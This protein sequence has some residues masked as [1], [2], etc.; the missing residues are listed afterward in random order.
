MLNFKINIS[1]GFLF[2]MLCFNSSL[3]FS[4][5]KDTITYTDTSIYKSNSMV[6]PQ[7]EI[8]PDSLNGNKIDKLMPENRQ[9]DRLNNPFSDMPSLKSDS[10]HKNKAKDVSLKQL[11]DSSKIKNGFKSMAVKLIPDSAGKKRLLKKL[12]PK[13]YGNI[14]AGYDYGVIPFAANA[15]YP[16]G[17]FKTQGNIGASILGIPILATYYYSDLKSVSGLNNYFRVSFDKA[18]YDEMLRTKGLSKVENEAKELTSLSTLKQILVQ[19]LAFSEI[20]KNGLPTESSLTSQLPKFKNNYNQLETDSLIKPPVFSDSTLKKSVVDSLSKINSIKKAA[21]SDSISQITSQLS[22]RDS[23][24]SRIDEFKSQ[25]KNLDEK[26]NAINKKL[27][28]FKN[29]QN[30][31][32]N[33]PHLT[34]FQSVLSGVKKLDIGL[35]YPNYSTFLVSG[36]SVKGINIEWE[37][38]FYFAFTYGKTINTVMTTNNLIQN[39]LQTARNLYNFFDFNN[40]K[41]S[42]KITALK[43]GY[44]KKEATHFYAGFLYGLGLPSYVS[45]SQQTNLE[46]N[47]VL[48][49]DGRIVLN[50]S[51]ALDL[52]YGKS[53][54]YQ[55]GIAVS[56]DNSTSQFPF[57]KH[58]SNAGLLKYTS[59]IKKTKTKITATGKIVDPFFNS[60]G[61]GFMRSDN[62]R[63]EL[64]VEQEITSKI[65]F[66]GSYRKDRDNLLN[67]FSYTTDLQ[68]I[69]TNLNIKINKRFTAKLSYMPV[70]QNIAS[71]DSGLHNTHNIN[72][73]SMAVI[74]YA[75]KLTKITSFFNAMFSYYQLSS[76]AGK[77]NSFQNYNINNTT[78]FNQHLKANFACNYFLNNDSDSLNNSTTLV[79]GDISYISTKGATLTFGA[80]YA[81]NNMV[82][83]QTG[84]LLKIN[85]PLINHTHLE[86]YAEKLILGD[87]Y[88]SYNIS[89]IKKFPFYCYGKVIFSW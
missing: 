46:K 68:T 5:T 70:I 57:S 6:N 43:F 42:R 49:L 40:V 11:A 44:G 66:S 56:S 53:A 67:T 7:N 37:K 80:K 51:N 71:K 15:S 65:K 21:Y 78:I 10:T 1:V 13:T 20:Y 81:Y 41:D 88:N 82:K 54:L 52:I 29:P 86:V 39:Q 25:L 64:K 38:K 74:T 24:S 17:Y 45:A 76:T 63:Y 23:V 32:E 79:S 2:S 87:F 50:K 55:N 33:N 36:S 85:I 3:I 59:E 47:L 35:C 34:K 22:K 61:V 18:K 12:I 62:I 83:N 8:T 84:G 9:I 69:V 26:I 16:L 48:E 73:I 75:P 27:A 58:R 60:Y 28:F 31:I 19:K 30:L 4:Q 72:N 89:E 14:S 77:S